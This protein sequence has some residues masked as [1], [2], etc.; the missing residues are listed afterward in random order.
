M[1]KPLTK[2]QRQR[3]RKRIINKRLYKL[4]LTSPKND[5]EGLR[6]AYL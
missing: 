4:M 6:L 3:E 1:T 2:K 5:K